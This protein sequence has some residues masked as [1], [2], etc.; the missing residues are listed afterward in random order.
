LDYIK[1]GL[2][3]ILRKITEVNYKLDLLVKIKIY[4]VQHITMLKP[5]YR[6]HELPLY[7]VDMY[8]R[9]KKDK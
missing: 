5:V 4:L 9:Q 6:N 3:K 7:E 8:K 2:F 1:L